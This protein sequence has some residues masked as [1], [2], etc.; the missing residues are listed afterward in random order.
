MPV[1]PAPP[2][3]PVKESDGQVSPTSNGAR[4]AVSPS[5]VNSNNSMRDHSISDLLD[6][7]RD[8]AILDPAGGRSSRNQHNNPS[9]GSLGQIAPWMTGNGSAASPAAPPDPA[10]A[11]FYNDSTDNLSLDSRL[12][13]GVRTSISRA[14]PAG[15][16]SPDAAYFTDERRPSVASITT[17]ASSQGSRTSGARGGIR[18]L[19]G[20]FGEEFPGRDSSETSL[21]QGKEHRSH[22]YSYSRPHRDRNYSNATD[23]GR[24]G[25]PASRPRTPV[26]APEVVPFLYQEA[27]VGD[28]T[29]QSSLSL[30]TILSFS[31]LGILPCQSRKCDAPCNP[32]PS[33]FLSQVN[34]MHLSNTERLYLGHCPIRGSPSS[35]HPQRP[36]SRPLHDRRF[37]ADPTQDFRL[38]PVRPFN[39]APAWPPQTQQEQRRPEVAAPVDQQGGFFRP[40][41]QGT[42]R[43]E[44]HVRH[45]VA[46]SEPGSKRKQW[47]LGL[48]DGC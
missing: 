32:P 8:L 37:C 43:F 22:S 24:D 11:T 35:R 31:C 34:I 48:Q 41:A 38:R 28:A 5:S 20:F 46:R 36:G 4:L 40:R 27:D 19:Q 18:K 39:R 26:P 6:Y 44:R 47:L 16:D 14:T 42:Q 13:P 10:P 17:T 33:F 15:T 21:G 3:S 7:R 45:E 30:D 1:S 29:P 2:P 25:S 23:H 9:T 12:S